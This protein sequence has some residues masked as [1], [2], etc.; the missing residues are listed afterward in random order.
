M[1]NATGQALHFSLL[2]QVARDD[3]DA[4]I[5]KTQPLLAAA[6]GALQ[7]CGVRH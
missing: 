2:L 3:L 7:Q 6:H 4:V 5:Q 1:P